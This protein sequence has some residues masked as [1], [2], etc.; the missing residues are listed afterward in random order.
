MTIYIILQDTGYDS[1]YAPDDGVYFVSKEK[2]QEK[3]DR[4]NRQLGY[5]PKDNFAPYSVDELTP[6]E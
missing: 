3:C 5:Q 4:L 6:A 1:V 2:A